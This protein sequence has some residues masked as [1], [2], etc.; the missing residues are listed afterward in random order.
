M[1]DFQVLLSEGKSWAN[2]LLVLRMRLNGMSTSRVGFSV[3]KHVGN[4]V[5]RNRVKRRLREAVRQAE[6]QDGWDMVFIVRGPAAQ[7]ELQ[8]VQGAALELLRRAQVTTASHD[9]RKESE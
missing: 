8:Q 1:A 5:V 6:L 9:D 2:R 7:A 4:A 3:S